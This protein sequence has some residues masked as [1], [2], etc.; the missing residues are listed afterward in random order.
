[1]F[2]AL[3][4]EIQE[5]Y[6]TSNDIYVTIK[7]TKNQAKNGCKKQVSISRKNNEQYSQVQE[8]LEIP[9]NTKNNTILN[10]KGKGNQSRN[11]AKGNLY[12]RIHIFGNN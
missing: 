12:V 2:D 5:Q 7:V 11:K 4:K 1:M 3:F 10:L 6:F 8:T 9:K